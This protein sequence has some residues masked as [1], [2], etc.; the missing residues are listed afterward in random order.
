MFSSPLSIFNELTV[1][2]PSAT[3]QEKDEESK[4]AGAGKSAIYVA[5]ITLVGTLGAALIAKPVFVFGNS[6]VEAAV[7]VQKYKS[8]QITAALGDDLKEI[9]ADR[10]AIAKQPSLAKQNAKKSDTLREVRNK[11]SD[12]KS[13]LPAQVEIYLKQLSTGDHVAAIKTQGEINA[14]LDEVERLIQSHASTLPFSVALRDLRKMFRL[15]NQRGV[16][17]QRVDFAKFIHLM[18]DEYSS[19]RSDMPV[20]EGDEF[21][22]PT[23]WN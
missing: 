22:G 8:E 3:T 21:C 9:E 14:R 13:A 12:V 20:P 7:A 16:V 4:K 17:Q 15:P 10:D 18:N 19:S 23:E 11:V 2:V 6:D 1:Y 5:L